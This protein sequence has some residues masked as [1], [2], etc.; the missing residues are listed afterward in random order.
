MSVSIAKGATENRG[1]GEN[2]NGE[3]KMNALVATA[4]VTAF[5]LSCTELGPCDEPTCDETI[6]G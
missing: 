6:W 2:R 5:V 1:P 4:S 3:P